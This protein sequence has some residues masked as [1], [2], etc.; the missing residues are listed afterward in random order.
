[1]LAL[2]VAL[3]GCGSSA[4]QPTG[5]PAAVPPALVL[6]TTTSA[7]DS[8]LLDVLLPKFREETGIAVDYVAV[9]TGQALEIGRRGDADL[10]LTHARPAEE[11]LVAEGFAEARTEV[12]WNDFVV[13]GPVG[14]PAGARHSADAL[15]ALRR[16]A[17]GEARFVSRGDDSGTHQ[18]EQRLW[19]E[20]KLEPSGDWYN[21]VGE[22]MAHTLRV[23][24]ELQA[25]TLA[26]RGTWLAQRNRLELAIVHAG[27]PR[28]VNQY[29]V[30]V[31]H[32]EKHPH[33]NTAAAR[34]F[35]EF[36]QEPQTQQLIAEFGREQF[37]EPLFQ[38]GSAA[39]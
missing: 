19:Q 1:M 37:A 24:N 22:G 11:A 38:A 33:R 13:V 27:D 14:D 28:L 26:D 20:L 8:G 36:L 29:A 34:K 4:G 25:Y 2:V 32:P 35:A 17:A 5:G 15:D 21:S 30:L 31:V 18:L 16:I 23:A 7:R 9:G 3:L 10:L 12:F 6:A 39:N